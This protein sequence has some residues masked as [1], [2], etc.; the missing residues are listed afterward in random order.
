MA[1]CFLYFHQNFVFM[2]SDSAKGRRNEG[3]VTSRHPVQISLQALFWN[4]TRASRRRW[5]RRSA[6]QSQLINN[7]WND[8][9]HS[10]QALWVREGVRDGGRADWVNHN[11]LGC[12]TPSRLVEAACVFIGLYLQAGPSKYQDPIYMF[13]K[14]GRYP[15]ECPIACFLCPAP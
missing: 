13:S 7:P 14:R 15:V 9:H 12:L 6:T 8:F 11:F 3:P 1:R 2:V 10:P 4:S 5:R